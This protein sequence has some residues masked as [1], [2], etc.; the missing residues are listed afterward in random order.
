VFIGPNT[1]LDGARVRPGTSLGP[2]CKVGGEIGVTIFQSRVN[3]A[4]DGFVGHTWAGRWVNFGAGSTTSNLKNTYG[5]IRYQRDSKT[6]WK[7]DAIPRLHHRRSHQ[8]GIGQLLTTG[9]NVGVGLQRV[10]R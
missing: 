5:T 4:H 1:I 3:K 2:H 10:R 7:L 6:T 9:S 8:I